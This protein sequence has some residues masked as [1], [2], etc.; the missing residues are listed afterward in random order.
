MIE[1]DRENKFE[2]QCLHCW[3]HLKEATTFDEDFG[4]VP[5]EGSRLD[6]YSIART[7]Y[8]KVFD[9]PSAYPKVLVSG[10]AVALKMSGN[11]SLL[12]EDHCYSPQT[13]INYICDNPELF[14]TDFEVFRKLFAKLTTLILV[15]KKENDALRGLTRNNKKNN[16]ILI[17]CPKLL[18]YKHLGIDLFKREQGGKW[19]DARPT[20]NLIEVSD[21]FIEYEQKF[22]TPK[23]HKLYE[24]YDISL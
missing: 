3:K 10:N 9:S 12:T 21:S 15:T 17:S 6:K 5:W 23:A 4:F 19:G 11:S 18:S 8:Q 14:L 13:F 24:E 1:I 16:S 20:D 22:W 2:V 7:G